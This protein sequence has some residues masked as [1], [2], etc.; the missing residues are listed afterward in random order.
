MLLSGRLQD[1]FCLAYKAD[2]GLQKCPQEYDNVPK[3][4]RELPLQHCVLRIQLSCVGLQPI[5]CRH[6]LPWLPRKSGHSTDCWSCRRS[7]TSAPMSVRL[8]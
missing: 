6:M 8:L 4:V 3:D 7:C 1:F 2:G 5:S